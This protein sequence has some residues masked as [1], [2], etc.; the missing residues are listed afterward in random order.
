VS[1]LV[2]DGDVES[3]LKLDA[4]VFIFVF[5]FTSTFDVVIVLGPSN[6]GVLVSGM[7]KPVDDVV[8][9][10]LTLS[11]FLLKREKKLIFLYNQ[12]IIYYLV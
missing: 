4:F 6:F 5:V 11:A 9:F 1:I 2:V 12:D 3:T 8:D 7:S 10:T